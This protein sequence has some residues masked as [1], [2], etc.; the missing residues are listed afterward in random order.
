MR[1]EKARIVDYEPLPDSQYPAEFCE[2][3]RVIKLRETPEGVTIGL[4]DPANRSIRE[5]LK[6][7]HRGTNATFVAVDHAEFS[8]YLSR[9]LSTEESGGADGSRDEERLA[10]DRLANDAPI[11]NLVNGILIDA[12]RARASDIHIEA[13]TDEAKVR[14]RVDGALRVARAFPSERFPAVSTRV[15]IMANL[16]IMERRLPQDGRITVDSGGESVDMRVSIVPIARGE[17]IVLRVFGGSK[18]PLPLDAIG[19][20]PQALSDLRSAF[21]VPHGLILVTGPTGSGKTTTLNS[22]LREI[23]DDSIKIITIEDPIEYVLDGIDQI[24]TNEKIGLGFDGLLRRVLRQDPNVIMV[25]EIRDSDTAELVM[26]A[27]LT[28]HL[29]FSTLHT[30]DSVSVVTRLRDLGVE[31]YLIASVLR[32]SMAQ[33][34]IRRLCPECSKPAAP[35]PAQMAAFARYGVVPDE[36]RVPVGC[37][38]CGGS[39]FAGRVAVFESFRSDEGLEELVATGARASELRAYLE[40][41]GMRSLARVALEKAAVGL[42]T[43]EEI[44]REIEL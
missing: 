31:G 5:S 33:R 14:F 9:M 19:F 23:R 20:E 43:V 16:N 6:H 35:G 24:Q 10:L 1:E 15:K 41:R 8:S 3:N 28:G 27:A 7:F 40:G 29:V 13:F 2:A 22:I 38:A 30:N 44:E 42:T 25:G 34:L 18:D 11:V 4:C 37:P 39:G 32:A 17:S 36:A 21:K 26:R 12:I